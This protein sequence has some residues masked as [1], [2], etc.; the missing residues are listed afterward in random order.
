MTH[1]ANVLDDALKG[2]TAGSDERRTLPIGHRSFPEII[3]L[4]SGRCSRNWK[5]NVW[6][7]T[8]V[9]VDCLLFECSLKAGWIKSWLMHRKYRR[10]TVSMFFLYTS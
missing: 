1:F 5:N 6:I 8:P 9:S 4:A 3:L 2:A 7:P 10:P